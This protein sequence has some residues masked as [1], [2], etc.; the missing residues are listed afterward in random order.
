MSEP[1]CTSPPHTAEPAKDAAT[2][3]RVVNAADLFQGEREICIA[4]DGERYRLRIT[5]RNRLILQ[6]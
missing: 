1:D 3:L 6:K 4:L 2:E 5:R